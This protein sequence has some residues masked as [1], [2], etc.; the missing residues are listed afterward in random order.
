MGTRQIL[1]ILCALVL[2]LSQAA[3][4]QLGLGQPE[5]FATE[6]MLNN[7]VRVETSTSKDFGFG[8]IFG[9]L[10][11]VLWIATAAHVIFP[12]RSRTPPLPAE[13][14][15]VQ[16]RGV[17]NWFVPA[18]P[19]VPASHDIAFIAI[20]APQA[21]VFW[22]NNIQ[23]DKLTLGQPLRIAGI[24]GRIAYSAS[25]TGKV[26][27]T[28]HAPLIEIYTGQEGQ[29]GAPVTSPEG[30]VGMY[31]KSAGDRVIPIATVRDEALKAGKPWQLSQA[32]LLP[33]AVRLCLTP[34]GES[35]TLPHINGPAGTVRRDADNCVQTMSGMN[36][37]VSPQQGVL[38]DPPQV[39]LPRDPLQ[40]LAV[41]C[42]VDP[43][44]IWRSKTDGYVTIAAQGSLWTIEGLQQSKYGVFKGL[45][46]GPPPHLQVQMH[47]QIG[48]MAF[49]T[50]ILEPRRLH[51]R[52]LVDGQN[53][54]VDLER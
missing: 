23:V 8:F 52:L 42:F 7:V 5:P 41:R 19:P 37:L 38:C 25:G 6:Q 35:T 47:T 20:S 28:A 17:P 13:G 11:D 27:G 39:N 12:D 51:G 18:A 10:G 9:R 50:L 48:S 43:V 36:I 45:L 54:D 14:I 1:R 22:R 44:G 32:P 46:T 24:N 16:L 31:Q 2:C 40:T 33:V 49:G 3:R 34:A 29:S 4:G 15:R 53:F 30:F 21:P 26:V